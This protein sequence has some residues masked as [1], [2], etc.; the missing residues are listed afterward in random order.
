MADIDEVD[1]KLINLLEQDAWQSSM[2]LAKILNVSESTL[3]RRLRQ[4]IQRG[5]VLAVAIT[6]SGTIPLPLSAM[7]A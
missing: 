7:I 3:R 2:A 6:D 5:V 4:L 1:N